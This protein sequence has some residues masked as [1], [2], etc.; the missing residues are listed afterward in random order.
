MR[1]RTGLLLAFAPATHG[2]VW[3]KTNVTRTFE[4]A[5]T[6]D[7]TFVRLPEPIAITNPVPEVRVFLEDLLRQALDDDPLLLEH[8]APP[9]QDFD[10]DGV[11]DDVDP[12]PL[13]G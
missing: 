10:D 12:T 4:P 8:P 6:Y 11:L 13:G 3:S 2:E 1:G 5:G 7:L 9:V